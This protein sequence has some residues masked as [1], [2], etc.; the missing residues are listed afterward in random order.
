[1]SIKYSER[2]LEV[3]DLARTKW[4]TGTGLAS[5]N[6]QTWAGWLADDIVLSFRLGAVDT[7]NINERQGYV[8][9]SR[10]IGERRCWRLLKTILDGPAE[11]LSITTEII[12]GP[13]I[14]LLGQL[15]QQRR[16]AGTEPMPVV[17]YMGL[18]WDKKIQGMT[19]AIDDIQIVAIAT[20]P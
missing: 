8:S 7:G 12:S 13:H 5:C 10:V 11:Y 1:M 19:V 14:I 16:Q 17:I 2:R 9:S 4:I 15:L 3:E 6:P 18:N 20:R